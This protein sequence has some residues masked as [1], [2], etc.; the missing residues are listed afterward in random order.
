MQRCLS[1]FMGE[2]TT[3]NV[4][5][6]P[7]PILHISVVPTGLIFTGSVSSKG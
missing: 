6:S 4:P 3:A 5:M 7:L 2:L 1:S